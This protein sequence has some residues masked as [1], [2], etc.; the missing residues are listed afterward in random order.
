MEKRFIELPIGARFR[1][2]GEE[3]LKIGDADT[4]HVPLKYKKPNSLKLS[5]NHRV[6]MGYKVKVEEI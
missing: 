1:A 6:V 4:S 5:N 3:F 2:Y